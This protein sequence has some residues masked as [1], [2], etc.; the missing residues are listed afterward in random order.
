M[1]V[2]SGGHFLFEVTIN[3]F[4]SIDF[5]LSFVHH[6]KFV[7][8]GPF[9]KNSHEAKLLIETVP[10]IQPN[11]RNYAKKERVSLKCGEQSGACS[12]VSSGS[13]ILQPVL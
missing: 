6:R 7:R 9:R 5:R 11:H 8:L 12:V 10:V 1:S 3:L 4:T 13:L 2:L